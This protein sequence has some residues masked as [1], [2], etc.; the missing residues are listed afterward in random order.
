[1]SETSH[2]FQKKLTVLHSRV[3]LVIFIA[4]YCKSTYLYAVQFYQYFIILLFLF[5][6]VRIFFP[7]II[8]CE[9]WCRNH[10]GSLVNELSFQ[11]K[12]EEDCHSRSNDNIR[13]H[14]TC[15]I[16]CICNVSLKYVRTYVINWTRI[17]SSREESKVL[18]LRTLPFLIIFL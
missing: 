15:V 12:M 3:S 9:I 10:T 17:F 18:R 11:E 2:L 1:M 6:C 7:S 14:F 16:F 13:R 8:W 4:N 5:C